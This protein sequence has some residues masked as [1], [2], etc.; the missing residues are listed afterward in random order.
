MDK[1]FFQKVV[2]EKDLIIYKKIIKSINICYMEDETEILKKYIV[3]G[4][5]GA[6]LG[7]L[8]FEKKGEGAALGVIAGAAFLATYYAIEKAKETKLPRIFEENGNLYEDDGFG[9]KTF[10]KTIEKSSV[11]LTPNFKIK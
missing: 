7:A 11:K 6:T 10:F 4:A 3:S 8:I 2:Y 1:V 5:I 9:N